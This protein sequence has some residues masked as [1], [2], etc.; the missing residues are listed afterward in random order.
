MRPLAYIAVLMLATQVKGQCLDSL[1]LDDSVILNSCEY[2][3]LLELGGAWPQAEMVVGPVVAFR[4][5]NSAQSVSKS[6]FFRSLVK[7]WLE[8]LDRPAVDWYELGADE[9][10]KTGVDA[11][12]VAWSKFKLSRSKRNRI[13]RRLAYLHDR[14][15]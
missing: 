10:E 14:R 1:G 9:R 11:I 3:T 4:Y 8:K 15:F 7:P 13:L 12:V 6:Y 5:G 2:R